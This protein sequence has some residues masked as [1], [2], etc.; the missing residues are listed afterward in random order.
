MLDF[1]KFENVD[2]KFSKVVKGS[3]EYKDT[4]KKYQGKWNSEEK[5]WIVPNIHIL[6]IQQECSIIK[7]HKDS[8]KRIKWQQALNHFGLDF[9]KKGTSE[10]QKVMDYYTNF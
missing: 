8:A 2:E 6:D 1:I 10:Y 5:V 4:L 3:F 7:S 9:V